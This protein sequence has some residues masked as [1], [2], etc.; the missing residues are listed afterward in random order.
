M[1]E[2]ILQYGFRTVLILSV[3]AFNL[4]VAQAGDRMD[5]DD[6]NH[7]NA[8]H[9]FLDG[10]HGD[11]DTCCVCFTDSCCFL[12]NGSQCD[13][14][15]NLKNEIFLELFFDFLGISAA[16]FCNTCDQC[17]QN[18]FSTSEDAQ[19]LDVCD[20]CIFGPLIETHQCTPLPPPIVDDF[21]SGSGPSC[22]LGPPNK[23][24]RQIFA[25][26]GGMWIIG[27]LGFRRRLLRTRPIK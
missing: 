18:N 3:V 19:F 5:D 7:D 2:K 23:G 17:A 27:G 21:L 16:G 4:G 8:I 13:A 1:F 14:E 15:G 26:F 22:R 9:D 20:L 10:L 24:S 6:D 12:I 25:L 11:G